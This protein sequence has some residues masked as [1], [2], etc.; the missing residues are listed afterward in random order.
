MFMWCLVCYIFIFRVYLTFVK[1]ATLI[2]KHATLLQA[3]NPPKV[4]LMDVELHYQK[5][6]IDESIQQYITTSASEISVEKFA[7]FIMATNIGLFTLLLFDT[8]ISYCPF[9]FISVFSQYRCIEDT[10]CWNSFGCVPA[11]DVMIWTTTLFLLCL[12]LLLYCDSCLM[13]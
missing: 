7:G 12:F 1:A 9:S 13:T 2:L 8:S 6:N 4:A 3:S 10:V 5:A 11:V